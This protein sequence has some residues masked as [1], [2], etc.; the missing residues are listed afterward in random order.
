M[1]IIALAQGVESP[2]IN[3]IR[4]KWSDVYKNYPKKS[5][6]EDMFGPDVYKSM[7]GDDYDLNTH[8]LDNKY[9]L[10]NACAAKVSIALVLSGVELKKISGI[11]VD[12]YARQGPMKN[13]GFISTASKMKLWLEKTWGGPYCQWKTSETCPNYSIGEFGLTVENRKGIYVMLAK[14]PTEFGAGGHVTLW[15]GG[16]QKVFGGNHYDKSAKAMYFWELK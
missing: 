16:N 8:L 15:I 3:P 6:T 14:N 7:Y 5:A 10:Y 4:P 9:E 2:P 11:G 13:K 1:A 12:F